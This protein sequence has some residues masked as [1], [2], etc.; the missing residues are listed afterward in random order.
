MK[1]SWTKTK[2]KQKENRKILI[3]AFY[4]RKLNYFSCLS[5]VMLKN[6]IS[7]K[8]KSPSEIIKNRLNGLT[9]LIRA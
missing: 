2:R 8:I 1:A 5:Q 4:W 9:F 3:T 6:L 7:K